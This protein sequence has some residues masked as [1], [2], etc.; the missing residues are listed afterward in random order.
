MAFS[1]AIYN[2]IYNFYNSVYAPK[3]SSRFDAHNKSELK[4]TYKYLQMSSEYIDAF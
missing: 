3:S 4:N 2:N 1:S